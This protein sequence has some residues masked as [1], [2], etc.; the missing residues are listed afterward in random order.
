MNLDL[1]EQ[2]GI[3]LSHLDG[4]IRQGRRLR[5]ALAEDST[6]DQLIA[7]TRRWQEECGGTI[8]Q[9]SG[10][11]KAHWLARAFSEAFL[12]R[13]ADGS[14][15]QGAAPA[16]IVDQLLEV[17]RKAV[18]VLSQE[19]LSTIAA[20]SAGAPA[21]R[22]FEFVRNREIR[23]VLEQAY[24]DGRNALDK[25]D[26]DFALITLSGILEAIVTDALEH[27]GLAALSTLNTPAGKISDWT[28]QT[29][30]ELAEKAGLIRTWARL[31]EA[32][33]KYREQAEGE[34]L[35]RGRISESDARRTAQVLQM[36]MRD[37]DP[38]R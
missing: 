16:E 33:R 14:A 31:P 9:L 10:G 1:Q 32:A 30:L 22:R 19:N 37:L 5:E 24:I 15:A 4:M 25:A 17:L 12:I 2:V 18:A 20:A 8:N 23:P 6:N 38:G 13:S 26:Y 11:S 34:E 3:Y 36:T 35:S 21:P 7:A 28:F 29:R 27:R